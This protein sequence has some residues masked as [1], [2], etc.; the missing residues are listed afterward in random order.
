MIFLRNVV[1]SPVRSGL[2]VLGVAAGI[3]LLVSVMAITVDVRHQI[4]GAIAAYNMEVVIY[5]RRANSPFSSRISPVQMQ[6]LRRRF[7]T[8]VAPLV[9]G[10]HN[11]PW[12]AYALVIGVP[13]EL[14]RR[15]PVSAGLRYDDGS[16][17][18][19]V[20]EIAANRLRIEPGQTVTL[21]GQVVR[22]SG[23]YRTGSR[24][25]DGG[26][27]TDLVRAQRVLGRVDA[28]PTY[29][30]AVLQG[31]TPSG[32]AAM[33]TEINR[34][35]PALKAIPGTE[36]AGA[37]RLL[38]VVDA[39]VRTISAVV[40]LGTALVVSN[41]FVMALAERTRDVGILMAIGWTPGMVLRMLLAECLF[42]CGVG[43]ALGNA[44]ALVLLRVVNSL[45]AVGFGWIPV[46][47]PVAVTGWSGV[48]AA[49]VAVGAL[50][51]PAVVLYRVQPIAALRHE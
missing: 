42:L 46:R 39:F 38:R 49:A 2:T 9:L 30:L 34:L 37:L 24:L 12:N 5:E 35:Y 41:T 17:E 7:G 11:E 8:R 43:A 33:V 31:G 16:R 3:G 10:T 20:G 47:L 40:I 48:L 36:F 27:M 6:E 22:V 21:D 50:I 28:E 29:T 14:L 45:D 13:P 1:R 44:F 15:V 19:M 26:V 51:W 18:V 25:F 32:A 23:V 4:S